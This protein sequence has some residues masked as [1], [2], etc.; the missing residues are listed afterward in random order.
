MNTFLSNNTVLIRH[1]NFISNPF[2]NGAEKRSAQIKELL[3]DLKT[4]CDHTYFEKKETSFLKIFSH[5]FKALRIINKYFKLHQF[6][7]IRRFLGC[8]KKVMTTF[9]I[10]EQKY[11][12]ESLLFI[13]EST[14]LSNFHLPVLVKGENG[15]TI[16]VPHNI[17]SLV[18]GQFSYITGSNSPTWFPDELKL[19]SLCKHV[20]TISR[21]ETWL[22]R[23]YGINSH[24]LPYFPPK[25]VCVELLKIRKKRLRKDTALKGKKQILMLGSIYNP[26]TRAGMESR[27]ALFEK[28][29]PDN[30]ELI[31]AGFGTEELILFSKE[32]KNNIWIAG[33]ISNYELFELLCEVDAVLIHQSPTTGALT[34]I[35]ELLLAGVPLIVNNDAARSY[36]TCNGVYVYNSDFEFLKLLNNP[37]LPMPEKPIFPT[38]EVNF[39]YQ[40]IT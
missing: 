33:S 19:F 22:L 28:N 27:I 37:I 36:Y 26:P 9:E 21:E 5:F 14:T 31:I 3:D 32:G 18:P 17:E 13:W 20:F 6:K 39:F 30:I 25:A 34:R 8:L 7:S 40:V 23:L 1:S 16:G 2:G 11:K 10:F 4:E 24:Y 12:G 15:I 29:K 38:Q 35:P